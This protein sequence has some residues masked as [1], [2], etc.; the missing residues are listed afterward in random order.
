MPGPRRAVSKRQAPD[1]GPPS[2]RR[3]LIHRIEIEGGHEIP[4]LDNSALGWALSI[5]QVGPRCRAGLQTA[6]RRAPA[7]CSACLGHLA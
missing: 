7:A 4:V 5:Q 2:Q 1:G 3:P 6:L